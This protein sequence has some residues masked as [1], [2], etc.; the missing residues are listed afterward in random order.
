MLH[1][2][3]YGDFKLGVVDVLLLFEKFMLLEHFD[4]VVFIRGRNLTQED[5]TES[6]FSDNCEKLK[7]I[8]FK[9]ELS[10]LGWIR[11]L[12]DNK[13]VERTVSGDDYIFI[14]S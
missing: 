3:H 2:F 10:E 5:F 11:N 12:S 1:I 14:S 7:I 4:S 9:L 6:S 13:H 8:D